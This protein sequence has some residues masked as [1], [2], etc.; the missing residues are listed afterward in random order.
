MS[1]V[2]WDSPCSL[3]IAYDRWLGKGLT[4]R[5][6]CA[7]R[8]R[9]TWTETWSPVSVTVTESDRSSLQKL[10]LAHIQV[11]T[12][13]TKGESDT[14]SKIF[15]FIW[16]HRSRT[17]P[18]ME[19]SVEIPQDIIDN[20][21]AAVGDVL[22]QCALVSFPFLLPSR[23]LLFSRITPRSKQNYQGIP[24]F[25][26][27][28]PVVQ[29]FVRTITLTEYRCWGNPIIPDWIN[30]RSLLAILRLPFSRLEC[31]SICGGR[32]RDVNGYTF[33]SSS[34]DW[35]NFCSALKD[36]LWDIIHSSTFNLKILSLGGHYQCADYPLPPPP[37]YHTGF[38]P[39]AE[40]SL[41][42][43]L[44]LADAGSFEGSGTNSFSHGDWSV[45]MAFR[46]G[47]GGRRCAQYETPFICCFSLIH[48]GEV[49]TKSIFLPFMRCLRFFKIDANPGL[50]TVHDFD[51]LSFLIG[52]L[53]I[54]LT[55][56]TPE[57]RHL[58]SW[59]R[60]LFKLHPFL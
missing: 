26:V 58:V 56:P 15:I 35:N 40:R 42:R 14:L 33:T 20:V 6:S 27:Q 21:I 59:I 37:P 4:F 30:G 38:V 55:S 28:N 34:C 2:Y 32:Y 47:G 29:S 9:A 57:V 49:H 24:K 48:N 18:H 51:I 50:A 12:D 52:S 53:C 43:E 23:K 44:N 11:I 19:K 36:A 41:W 13:A 39:L 60:Y 45:S 54:S 46:W 31:F 10:P 7:A 8:S 25:L 17:K 5:S 3:W 16:S 22:K 1:F